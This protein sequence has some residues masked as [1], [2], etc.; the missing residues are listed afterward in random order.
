MDSLRLGICMVSELSDDTHVGLM[1]DFTKKI[2]LLPF[3][4]K[5]VAM[6]QL[7]NN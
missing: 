5:H 2:V 6:P 1:D 3:K 4:D 7:H